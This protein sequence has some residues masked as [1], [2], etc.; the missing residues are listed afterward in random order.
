MPRTP[1]SVAE[2]LDDLAKAFRDLRVAWYIFGAQ[3]LVLRGFPRATA[4]LDVTVLLGATRMRRL[5]TV[6]ALRLGG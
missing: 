4:T 1:G 3:A 5:V 6:L 2:V